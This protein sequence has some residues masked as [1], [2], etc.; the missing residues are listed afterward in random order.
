[1]TFAELKQALFDRLGDQEFTPLD[2]TVTTVERIVNEA[3][4]KVASSQ[5]WYWLEDAQKSIAMVDG[6]SSYFLDAT[7]G[8]I[9]ELINGSGDPLSEVARDTFE[10]L[11]RGDSTAAANPTRFTVDGMQGSSRKIGITVWPEPSGASTVTIRGYRRIAEMTADSDVPEIP[12]ELHHLIVDQAVA[13][14]REYEESP[15]AELAFAKASQGLGT[16]PDDEGD[17]TK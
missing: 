16:V 10:D 13:L 12:D 3:A 6:T 14:L 1:M 8:D 7:I 2:S 9:V 5:K 4:N 11:Y 15:M 17:K